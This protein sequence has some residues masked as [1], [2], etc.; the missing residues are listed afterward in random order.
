MY[1]VTPGA[2][3]RYNVILSAGDTFSVTT[4]EGP[5]TATIARFNGAAWRPGTFDQLLVSV[6]LSVAGT[7]AVLLV[8][9]SFPVRMD[10]SIV[11]G[12]LR[13]RWPTGPGGTIECASSLALPIWS[14]VTL[15]VIERDG[16]REVDVD[17]DGLARFY[18]IR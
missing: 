11:S 6:D 14:P 1:T 5:R 2:P 7:S 16:F 12:R 4:P 15:P 9:P 10:A 18:R 8:D 13:M 17:T 3:H